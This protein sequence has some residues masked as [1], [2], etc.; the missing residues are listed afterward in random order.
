MSTCSGL[1][2]LPSI[3]QFLA[4]SSEE[5]SKCGKDTHL[6]VDGSILGVAYM[7]DVAT[8]IAP[9]ALPVVLEANESSSEKRSAEA[10]GRPPWLI[11]ATRSYRAWSARRSTGPGPSLRRM[12]PGTA[13]P[14]VCTTG[15][16]WWRACDGPLLFHVFASCGRGPW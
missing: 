6:L 3:A 16:R 11:Q 7:Q 12:L 4:R 5:P 15:S 2:S 9:I 1:L 8:L 10:F 14:G 13:G